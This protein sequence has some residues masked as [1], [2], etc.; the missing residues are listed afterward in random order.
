MTQGRNRTKEKTNGQ[1]NEKVPT[2]A[3]THA[4]SLIKAFLMTSFEIIFALPNVFWL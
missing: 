1:E 3:E 4:K 2:N